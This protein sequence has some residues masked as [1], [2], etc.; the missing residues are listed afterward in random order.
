MELNE[1][2]KLGE[3]GVW[4]SILSYIFLSIFKVSAGYFFHS[5]ALYADGLNNTTDIIASVAVLIGL[6]ISRR[7]ADQNHRYGHYRA[8]TIAALVASFI[9]MSVGLLVLYKSVNT[10]FADSIV[11][12]DLLTA[13]VAIFSAS[14]LL[15]VYLYNI[16]LAKKIN[17]SAIKAVALDNRSDAL[18]SIGAFAGIIGARIGWT[19]LD[20]IAAIGVGLIICKTA[21][22]I[23]RDAS[24]AL[25]D[26]FDEKVLKVYKK[27]IETVTGVKKVQDIKA[28]IHGNNV[29]LDVTIIVDA[30]LNVVQSHDI[31]DN[32]EKR[33]DLIHQVDHVHIHVE[34]SKR[35]EKSPQ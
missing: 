18:V 1:K 30:D 13:W 14:V 22:D 23:F 19:W 20:P 25:T 15:M 6:K 34:P 12:P 4:I 9:M 3:K 27:T 11:K 10:F 16:K 8:E 31:S 33:M 5:E 21:V 24:H 35:I 7:P 2:M 29:L 26:G 32:I 28:R 17:S